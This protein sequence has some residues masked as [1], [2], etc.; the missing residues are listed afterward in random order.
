MKTP[1]AAVSRHTAQKGSA[2]VEFAFVFPLL[3][4]LIYGVIVYSYVYVLQSSINYAAQEGARAILGVD[5]ASGNQATVATATVN[6]TLSWAPKSLNIGVAVSPCTLAGCNSSTDYS[7]QVTGDVS[8]LFPV[9]SLGGFMGIN[10]V[11]PL[12]ATLIAQAVV[13]T[14]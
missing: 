2:V 7:V 10:A 1:P 13:R 9:I 3:L 4:L 5:P 11:P 6:A 12:P 8:K 14:S